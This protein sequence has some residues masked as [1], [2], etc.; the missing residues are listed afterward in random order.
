[1]KEDDPRRGGPRKEVDA[2]NAS[3]RPVGRESRD[4]AELPWIALGF[5][6]FACVITI[7]VERAKQFLRHLHEEQRNL[8]EAAV[9]G[10]VGDMEA[11]KFILTSEGACFDADLHL[12]DGY[13]RMTAI[14]RSG[15]PQRM[16][17]FWNK[18][19]SIHDPLNRARQRSV[20][21]LTGRP[22]KLVATLSVLRCLESG[23]DVP[24]VFTPAAS[25]EVFSRHSESIDALFLAVPSL[26]Q[27][28]AGL[29]GACVWAYPIDPDLVVEFAQKTI[30]GEMI[31]KGS[32]E[33]AF[34]VWK[35]SLRATSSH[36]YGMALAVLNCLRAKISGATLRGVYVG[37]MG[38]RA[39]TAKRRAMR[40]PNT[41]GTDIVPTLGG[42]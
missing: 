37:E 36:G 4:L 41:P 32:P 17:V 13:H 6:L 12:I 39:L 35:E 20:S 38:Y 16:L 23:H 3:A 18:H 9:A 29:H 21:F 1:M 7:T 19:G 28:V 27:A 2:P 30:S 31:A 15:K 22:A 11:G 26:S 34:R 42:G 14:V 25:D 33:Y 24:G 10:L 5:G 8:S 40:I